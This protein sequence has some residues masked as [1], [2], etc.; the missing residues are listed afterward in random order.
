MW[1]T[2][3][4]VVLTITLCTIVGSH[5][6]QEA[7]MAARVEKNDQI[8]GAVVNFVVNAERAG[9]FLP[10]RPDAPSA[11]TIQGMPPSAGPA[12]PGAEA[13]PGPPGP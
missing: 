10:A 9:R 5:L 3:A 7:R 1:R 8:L 12:Q 4:V 13:L 2:V 6:W 11:A